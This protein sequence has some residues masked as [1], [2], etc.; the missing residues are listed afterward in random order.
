MGFL[1][2]HREADGVMAFKGRITPIGIDFGADTLKA[3]QVIPSDPPQLVAAGYAEV[4]EHARKD[5][6]ARQAFYT[7][8][9]KLLLKNQPFKGKR[10]ICSIPS[11]QTLVHHFQVPRTEQGGVD[12]HVGILLRQR[13]NVDPTRMVL[14]VHN[15][16]QL[17]RDTTKEEVICL[18]AG[19][20]AVM[21]HI[22]CAHRAKVDVIG[23]QCEP[24]AVLASFAHLYQGAQNAERT[25]C[26]IDIGAATTKVLIANGDKLVFAKTIHA[27][28]DHLT[29][30]RAAA[31]Q[32]S[33][34]E[35]KQLRK[36]EAG[37]GSQPQAEGGVAVA[38]AP[39]GDAVSG[40]GADAEVYRETLECIVDELQMCI[41]YYKTLFPDRGIDKLVFVG[42]ES[43]HREVCATIAK[44]VGIGAQLGDPLARLAKAGRSKGSH[45][46]DFSQPQPGWSVPLGLCLSEK[47][48]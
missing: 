17:P 3:L 43:R 9:L 44:S 16:G 6:S 7:D 35:A 28:G 40:S 10:V 32:L 14:R 26:F 34:T 37:G 23:M 18:A 27:G 46:V 41:R 38:E 20:D 12:D 1:H 48:L 8:S 24:M 19:K 21:R 30:Q 2:E 31:E 42:G 22:E 39:S 36:R 13:L 25:T 5:P 29:R 47:N 11:Y 15:V 4:P 45:A 33:F